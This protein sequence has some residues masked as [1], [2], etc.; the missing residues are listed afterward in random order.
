M[1]APAVAQGLPLRPELVGEAPYGAPQLDVDV[2]LNVNE[3]PYGPSEA[4]VAQIA[5]AA[6]EVARDLNRY[7]ERDAVALRADLAAYLGHGL[8]ADHVWAANGSNEVMLHVLQAFAGP[9]RTVLSF[10][11]TY[12]MYP[13][14]ARDTH[15]GFV[16]FPRAEDF[17]IDV[18]AAVA[19]IEET[20]PDVVL[21]T[22]P[23]N[24]TG[25]A[26]PPEVVVALV[27]A[28]PGVVV[29]DEAYHEFALTGTP[30]ALELL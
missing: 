2:R 28:S 1:S 29:V 13:E 25:T 15:S 24:P 21:V 10:A 4:V 26:L 5:A 3:N 19:A 30:S 12:S 18:D 9:G 20:R 8:T 7:P 27:D 11:P 17:T 16:T 14:Y 6:A 22:S 23:N